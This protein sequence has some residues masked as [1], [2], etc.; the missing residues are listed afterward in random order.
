MRGIDRIA[1]AAGRRESFGQL[2]VS[3]GHFASIF[4]QHLAF[5]ERE[6]AP[7]M[8]ALDPWGPARESELLDEHLEQRKRVEALCALAEDPTSTMSELRG[9]VRWLLK[10][11]TEDM[12]REEV[13]IAALERLDTEGVAQMTG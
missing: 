5:E 12:D 2:K 6:L 13:E 1:L 4:E 7:L 11:L 8:R 3:L 10:T 9:E